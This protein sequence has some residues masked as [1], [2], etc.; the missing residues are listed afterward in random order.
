MKV[1]KESKFMKKTA[2]A[3]LSGV[4]ALLFAFGMGPFG[5]MG[6]SLEVEAAGDVLINETNFP[7]AIFREYVSTNFDRNMDGKLSESEIQ[8]V[9]NID[10]SWKNI[11]S[12]KGVEIFTGL[13]KLV[14]NNNQLTSLDV[15]NCKYLTELECFNNKLNGLDVSKC[16]ALKILECGNNQLTS[17]DVTNCPALDIFEC[18]GNQLSSLDVSNC[19]SLTKLSCTSN[20]LINLDV[21][22]CTSLTKLYCASNQLINLDVSKCIVIEDL[23]CYDNQL[24]SL[25]V[26]GCTE[27]KVLSCIYNSLTSLDVSGCSSLE[28]IQCPNNKLVN[29]NVSGCTALKYLHCYCNFLVSL[30]LSSCINLEEVDCCMN[31]LTDLNLNGCGKLKN[32]YCATNQLVSLDINDCIALETL[33]CNVNQ[34]TSLDVSN[35]V[36]LETLECTDNS[37]NIGTITESYSLS[38]LPNFDAS[39]ASNWT[40]ATY[41]SGSNS[42]IEFTDKTVTYVY[43]CGNSQ[44]AAFTLVADSIPAVGPEQQLR[45]FVSR[46]YTVALGR[47][48]EVDGLDFYTERL[49]A[50]DSNGACLAESFL[51]S[52]EF[53]GKGYDDAQYVKVLYRTFFDREPAGEEVNY[54]VEKI[55][56]GQSREFVLSGFVNSV[57][58]DNLCTSYGIS[59][60]FMKE[61]GKPL[62]P[63]IGRFVERFYTV[64]LERAGE[65][66]G[67]EYWSLQMA[68]GTCT[69]KDAAKSFFLSG[70]YI[71]KNTSDEKYI[72]TLYKTFMDREPE[73]GGVEYWQGVLNDGSTREQILEGFADSAEFKGIMAGFGL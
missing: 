65:K 1:F 7:D 34:L 19:T 23:S 15:T 16:L 37:F 2:L 25:E 30:D 62:N 71:N 33:N 14:C 43:D 69:P 73:D 32:L 12:L 44:T 36:A 56:S 68:N 6:L 26:K 67:I 72:I 22:N 45:A 40:G 3:L 50:G 27:L 17:I 46:M 18:Y 60:G 61:D 5:S 64:V 58:F 54:W 11:T 4:V 41:D 29:L 57:E 55:D 47:E 49:L 42:L 10:V 20:Q 48:A 24:T 63:G 9:T 53:K 66:E 39:K 70:E 38:G 51:T 8:S 35:C 52:P 21:S 31:K 13:E 28:R 59:R